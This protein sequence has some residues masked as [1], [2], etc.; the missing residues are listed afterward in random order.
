MIIE[1]LGNRNNPAILLIPGMFCTHTFCIPFAKYLEDS[2]YIILPTL[3]GHH[4]GTE[5]ISKEDSAK[6]VLAY[7]KENNIKKLALLQG[8]SMGAEVAMEI[9]RQSDIQIDKCLF[10]GGPF[11]KF[12]KLFRKIMENKFRGMAKIL[13]NNN[14]PEETADKFLNNSF[15]KWLIGKDTDVYKQM[16]SVI[17]DN[18]NIFTEI[19]IKNFVETCYNF[20]LHDFSE[21]EQ[22]SFF[23]LFSK[24][25]PARQ[26]KK[27]L[28]KK[29]PH[30]LF[31]DLEGYGHGGFQIAEPEKYAELLRNYIEG[32]KL[33]W[34]I[35]LFLEQFLANKVY[36]A[37]LVKLNFY[38]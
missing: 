23:F 16:I 4:K 14:T 28:E 31:E 7:L 29:Y 18:D 22:K 10:D 34:F 8:T 19:T 37:N 35:M 21:D 3:D 32:K 6:K 15:I 27:R 13:N 20:I 33:F 1:T 17:A 30:A 12:P 36:V 5:Y 26:S 38:I 2:Y 24:N 11:F 9:R 25:E